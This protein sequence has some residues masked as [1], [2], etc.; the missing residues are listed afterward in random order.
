MKQLTLD[1]IQ[2]IVGGYEFQYSQDLQATIANPGALLYHVDEKGNH[3]YSFYG[4]YTPSKCASAGL[5]GPGPHYQCESQFSF[6]ADSVVKIALL[7][8]E[9]GSSFYKISIQSTTLPIHS[10]VS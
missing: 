7:P 4:Y 6:S 2:S 5:I 8:V 1:T 9:E 3:V 10:F